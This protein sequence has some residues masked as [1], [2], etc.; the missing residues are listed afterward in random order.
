MLRP[1]IPRSQGTSVLPVS[2]Q[3]GRRV[4]TRADEISAPKHMLVLSILIRNEEPVDD[5]KKHFLTEAD[6]E[7]FLKSALSMRCTVEIC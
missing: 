3:I 7:K 1:A 2:L 4:K 5:R 6:V